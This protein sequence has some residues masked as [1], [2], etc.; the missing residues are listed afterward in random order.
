VH[1]SGDDSVGVF[2]EEN[3]PAEEI[4]SSALEREN[5]RPMSNTNNVCWGVRDKGAKGRKI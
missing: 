2:D 5:N 3:N 1:F 4:C